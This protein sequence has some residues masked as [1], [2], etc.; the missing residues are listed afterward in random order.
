MAVRQSCNLRGMGDAED[1]VSFGALP[2]NLPDL[3]RRLARDAAVDLVVNDSRN[4]IPV[5]QGIFD[6]QGDAAQLAA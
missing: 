6:G 3:P 5:G 2:Q 1:L 4:S